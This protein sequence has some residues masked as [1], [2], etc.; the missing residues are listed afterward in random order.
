[1]ITDMKLY[2]RQWF[3]G[4]LETYKID[5]WPRSVRGGVAYSYWDGHKSYDKFLS[6]KGIEELAQEL[7]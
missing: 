1:M 2:R 5:K 6:D 7:G 4:I 3:I